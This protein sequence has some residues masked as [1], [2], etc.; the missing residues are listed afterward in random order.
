MAL[1]AEGKIT[2]YYYFTMDEGRTEKM[3]CGNV[4][5]STTDVH[6]VI[7]KDGK[8]QEIQKGNYKEIL[9][10]FLDDCPG[11][12]KQIDDATYKFENMEKIIKKYNTCQQ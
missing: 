9:A 2:L 12:V 6:Y 5:Y 10:K 7:R 4:T 3:Y 11:A 8:Y 1:S